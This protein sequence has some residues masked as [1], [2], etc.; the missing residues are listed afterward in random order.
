MAFVYKGYCVLVR[1]M[2]T[3]DYSLHTYEKEVYVYDMKKDVRG[4]V[5]PVEN[6]DVFRLRDIVEISRR[7]KWDKELHPVF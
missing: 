5:N 1:S 7:A 2:D 6:H 4:T 3:E